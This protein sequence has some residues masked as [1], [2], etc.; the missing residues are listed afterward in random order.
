M[1]LVKTNDENSFDPTPK[2]K[3]SPIPIKFISFNNK[4]K[5]CI[6]CGE[7]Y[8]STLLCYD[9]KYCKKCLSLYTNNITSSDNNIY[10][11]VYIYTMDLEKCNEHEISRTKLLLQ[12]IQQYCVN[13]STILCFKQ[14]LNHSSLYSDNNHIDAYNK[15]IESEKDCK[16]CGKSLYQVKDI[17]VIGKYK[18]CSSCYIISKRRIKNISILYLPWWHDSSNCDECRSRLTFTSDHQKYCTNCYIC[19]IGCRYCLTTNI[20]FG[21]TN[22]SQCEEN[23][24]ST[25]TSSKITII[26]IERHNRHVIIYVYY[27]RIL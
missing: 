20:I 16:L 7:E 24:L 22:K 12:R 27:P 18:L 21:P 10:L 26:F 6:Y 11:D 9:Q 5:N 17:E 2:L 23:H 14:I 1:K 3:S 4:D 15:V 13:C 8:T 19:Y 25:S